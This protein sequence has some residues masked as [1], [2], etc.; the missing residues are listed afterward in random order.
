MF[1]LI[2][3]TAL[4]FAINVHVEL[5]LK[6]DTCRYMYLLLSENNSCRVPIIYKGSANTTLTESPRGTVAMV[7]CDDGYYTDDNTT[8]FCDK[9]GYWSVI[10]TCKPNGTRISYF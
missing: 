1:Y 4:S 9:Y 7:T 2:N 3:Q 5:I 6:D 8:I 10:P